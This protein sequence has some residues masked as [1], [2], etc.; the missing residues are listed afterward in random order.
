M[1]WPFDPPLPTMEARTTETWPEGELAYEPKWDGFRVLAWGPGPSGEVRL[2]SRNG[3]PLLRYFPELADPLG[4]LPGGTVVDGEVVVVVGDVT[5]F[6]SLQLRIHPAESRIR[7]L[8][9]ELPA[10]LVAFDLLALE[11]RDLRRLPF[12]ER[13]AALTGLRLPERWHLTPSTEDPATARRWFDEFEAAGCDGIVAKRLDLEYRSGERAMWKVKHRRTVDC[14]VGGYRVHKDGGKV[15]S[16]LLGLYTPEGD[17]TF[18]GHCS[19]FGGQDPAE[20]LALLEELRAE[21]SFGG[22]GPVRV[23]GG[24]SRWTGGRDLSWVPVRPAVVVEVSYDQL[25]NGRFRHA[26]RFHRWRPD[27]D[28]TECTIDQLARPSGPGF[29]RVVG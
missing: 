11:G 14:V 24:E 16:I 2:D 23:P 12:R 15:G 18:V 8:A 6:D 3:R 26:T 1:D 20:I 10:R 7:R 5:S 13:R 4:D 27:K 9:E 17:L 19:G 22:D 29:S 21:E 25:E 28:P